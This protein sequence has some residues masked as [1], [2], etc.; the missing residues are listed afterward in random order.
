MVNL[1]KKCR[2]SSYSNV[3]GFSNG[4]VMLQDNILTLQVSFSLHMRTTIG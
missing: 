2:V 1:L 3:V 4:M